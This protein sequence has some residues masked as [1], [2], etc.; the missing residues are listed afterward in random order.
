M[1]YVTT[2]LIGHAAPRFWWHEVAESGA[3]DMVVSDGC[4]EVSHW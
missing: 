3:S 2:F 1:R 4:Y